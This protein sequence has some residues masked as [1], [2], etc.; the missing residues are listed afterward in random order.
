MDFL[1]V[2]RLIGEGALTKFPS[3]SADSIQDYA[4][5]KRIDISMEHKN[6]RG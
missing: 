6:E 4:A 3:V 5:R 1:E 2:H